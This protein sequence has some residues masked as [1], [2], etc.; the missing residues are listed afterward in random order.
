VVSIRPNTSGE[1]RSSSIVMPCDAAFARPTH[2]SG[3]GRDFATLITQVSAWADHVTIDGTGL[4][5]KYDWDLQWTP[6]RLDVDPV[7]APAISLTTA[8]REQLGL[9]LEARRGPVDVLVI[10]HAERPSAN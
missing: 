5:G 7:A 9:K 8:L 1:E 2:L 4:T 3:R 6:D 10:T